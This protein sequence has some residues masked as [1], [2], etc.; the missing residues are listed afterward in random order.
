M[1]EIGLQ[2]ASVGNHEFDE[3]Y[4][5]LKRM[6][7]GGCLDDGDGANGQDSCP[8]GQDF[9]GA[10]FQYLAANAKFDDPAAHGGQRRP[11]S[12]PPRSSRSR[13]RRSPSSA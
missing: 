2:V 12:R 4:R 8:A 9:T 11:S 13:A 3:G 5:E 7:H 6:Q 1:N 10:D